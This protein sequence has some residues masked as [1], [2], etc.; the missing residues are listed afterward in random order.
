MKY[1]V[2]NEMFGDQPF[3]E[4]WKL[5]REI[6]YTGVEIAPFTFVPG[7][8]VVDASEISAERRTKVKQQAADAG[9]EVVGL[10]WIAGQDRGVLFD[11]P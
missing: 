8:E 3:D 11:E 2:C 4:A 1:A 9:L 7:A 5:A 6:G 10:H